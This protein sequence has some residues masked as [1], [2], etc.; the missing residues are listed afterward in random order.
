MNNA[1][2]EQQ[3]LQ[4][5]IAALMA[6]NARLKANKAPSSSIKISAKGAVSVYGLGRF[7]ITLYASQWQ[8]LLNKQE[9]IKAFIT[10][11]LEA[12]AKKEE[13]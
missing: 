4:A 6:E 9:D 13:A 3:Q 5:Q 11:N 2:T 12:L 8:S 1:M 7:P 10:A